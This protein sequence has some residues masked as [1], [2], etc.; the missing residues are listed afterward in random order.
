MVA[1]TAFGQTVTMTATGNW[2][3]PTKWNSSDIGD[4]LAETVNFNNSVQATIPNA[5]LNYTVGNTSLP[6][7]NQLTIQNT[8]TLNIGSSGNARNLTIGNN[9]VI[10]VAAGA[11]LH[12]WGAF[13]A[14][15]NFSFNISG[16]VHIHGS[17]QFSNVNTNV[18][19]NTGGQL[20]IDGAM[21][22]GNNVNFNVNGFVEVFGALAVGSGS[23]LNGSGVFRLHGA[24]SGTPFCSSS[25]MPVELLYFK[26]RSSVSRVDLVW[27]T[28]SELD[29]DYFSIEK[30]IDGKVFHE[31]GKITSMGDSRTERTYSFTDEK[32]A[33]GTS[34][35]KLNE[36]SRDGSKKALSVIKNVFDGSREVLIYPNPVLKDQ[37]VSL[38]LNFHASE[39][40]DVTVFDLRGVVMGRTTMQGSEAN[41]PL[42]LSAGVYIL[43]VTS[44]EF[45]SVQRIV[46][47]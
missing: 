39:T 2:N 15:G 38:S 17:S 13:Q 36:V 24:C 40:H 42:Q 16:T 23:N 47:K 26:A 30:S 45:S 22:G 43:R 5:S 29:V 32:P 28:A 35:F 3:D 33:H 21:A 31:I 9:G 7:D 6:Q 4:A 12:I 19:V 25:V 46:V 34:F 8:S 44:R 37:P 11:T 10:T 20:I 27:A 1:A 18:T 41:L 14:T